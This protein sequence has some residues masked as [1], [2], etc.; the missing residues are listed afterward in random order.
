[1]PVREAARENR[2]GQELRILERKSERTRTR[3]NES[4]DRSSSELRVLDVVPYGGVYSL[5]HSYYSGVVGGK[6]GILQCDGGNRAEGTRTAIVTALS[7]KMSTSLGEDEQATKEA[8]ELLLAMEQ[9]HPTIPDAVTQYFLG[10]SGYQSTDPRVTR[11][12][13]IAA[14]KFVADLTNDA[15]RNCKNR[16]QGKGRLVLTTEDLAQAAREYGIHIRKS[17]YF[18]DAPANP[19]AHPPHPEMQ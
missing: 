15:L 1:M 9:Y 11:I 13:S 18:A 19:A 5:L 12:A 4:I 8:E 6:V 7:E 2:P 3:R 16:Q 10:L 14:H 17:S